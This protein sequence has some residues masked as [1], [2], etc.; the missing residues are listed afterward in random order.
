MVIKVL[1]LE[2]MQGFKKAAV[3]DQVLREAHAHPS[4]ILCS[5]WSP[6]GCYIMCLTDN[7]FRKL[8]HRK[9]RTFKN[10]CYY[11]KT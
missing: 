2:S 7:S 6:H 1:K 10:V 8:A 4:V 3:L 11:L 5:T 9:C